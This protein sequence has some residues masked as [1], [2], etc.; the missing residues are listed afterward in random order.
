[1]TSRVGILRLGLEACVLIVATEALF[2]SWMAL[3]G[4]GSSSL[5]VLWQIALEVAAVALW[6]RWRAAALRGREA[7]SAYSNGLARSPRALSTGVLVV[8][9]VCT[10][11]AAHWLQ[12]T[13][14]AAAEA[15]FERQKDRLVSEVQRRFRLPVYA[16][17]GARGIFATGA[18][19]DREAWQGYVQ[20]RA[21]MQ[22]FP[23]VRGLG[24]IERVPR[25]DV[26]RFVQ[27]RRAEGQ[28]DYELHGGGNGSS[29]NNNSGGQAEVFAIKYVEPLEANRSALG[30]DAGSEPTRRRAIEQAIGSGQATLSAPLTLVQDKGQGTGFLYMVPVYSPGTEPVTPLQRTA[31]LTAVVYAPIVASELLDGVLDSIDADLAFS[32]FDG[33]EEGGHLVFSAESPHDALMPGWLSW[34]PLPV[35]EPSAASVVIGGRQFSMRMAPDS[36]FWPA[37]DYWSPSLIRVTGTAISALLA[38]AVWLLASGEARARA[39]AQSMTRDLRRLA[40]VVR[41]TSNA[42]V[43]TDRARRILWVNEGFTRVYG[44][45]MGEALGSTPLALLGSGRTDPASYAAIDA[46]DAAGRSCRV[47]VINRAK[48]GREYWIDLEIQPHH[49]EAGQ[50]VGFMQIGQ[51]V[52]EKKLAAAELSRERQRLDQII[53][54][55]DAGAWEWDL[56]SGRL[57]CNER[58]ASMVGYTLQ[59]LE[60][61]DVARWRTLC[62]RSDLRSSASLLQRYLDGEL[63]YFECEM[64]M[65]HR[66]GHWIWVLLRGRVFDRTAAGRPRTMSGTQM[67]ITERKG[68]EEQLRASKSFLERAERVAGVGGWEVDLRTNRLTWSEQTFRIFGVPVGQQPRL[69][70]AFDFFAPAER[71]IVEQTARECIEQRKPWNL[72]LPLTTQD[73]AAIWI[74]SVGAVEVEDDVPVRLV[75]TL[76]DISV[77]R[78]VREELRRSNA[79]LRSILDNLPCGLSVFDAD[80]KLAAYN[81]AYRILLDLPPDLLL[82]PQPTFADIIRHNAA[83]GDYGPGTVDEIVERMVQGA[84]VPRH[85]LSERQMPDGRALEVRSAP[86]PGGGFVTTYMDI[87]ERRHMERLKS[88]FVSTVTHELRTPMTAIHGALSLLASGMAGE[89]PD[90]AGEL[91]A[92]SAQSSDRLVRLINDVLDVERIEARL[93]H[94]AMT[95]QPLAPLVEQ[96]MDAT[97]AYAQQH[98]VELDLQARL[99][100]VRVLADADRIVQVMVN[101]LSN[102]VKFT[103]PSKRVTIRMGQ[104]PSA[105]RVSVIDDGAGIPE[106]FR[107]RIFERFSQ[108]DSSDRRQKGGTGLGLNICRSIVQEHGGR[109]DYA[110]TLGQGSEFFFE[111][112]VV[113]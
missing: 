45:S 77:V 89:L 14:S 68:A 62:H 112:P 50:L 109:I 40:E 55:T 97:R 5:D 53:E 48:D 105:V 60:P 11:L 7:T 37:L 100:D 93:M 107:G 91:V 30:Y 59:E 3:R 104:A 111:L 98:G 88:E 106:S 41:H 103:G 76:Q 27:A 75:G 42:V 19:I 61:L 54:G 66:A 17:M 102:A 15:K 52:T 101:L 39:L 12:R 80:L 110:S 33:A 25:V 74:R 2:L 13:I 58:W 51:D 84:Q 49:D 108:A 10:M 113:E 69:T 72:E 92:R 16:L 34:R 21:L 44:Y 22:E 38:L 20:S 83:R 26:E 1:M 63:P 31:A 65:Q 46:A 29:N 94:Y 70:G 6:I 87:T 85:M 99:D 43:I 57:T 73:G 9:I 82:E 24:I 36:D 28:G 81:S 18:H 71:S 67:D 96:A 4:S 56:P 79:V 23:G 95:V 90:A 47:E 35:V 78:N 86:M 32:L 64:R 8:G